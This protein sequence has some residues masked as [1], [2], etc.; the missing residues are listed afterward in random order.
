FTLEATLEMAFYRGGGLKYIALKGKGT[1]ASAPMPGI[2]EKIK[3]NTQKLA[4][5]LQKIDEQVRILSG[6][7]LNASRESDAYSSAVYGDASLPE[8]LE[9][10]IVANLYITYDADNR[11]LHGN[12]E[13]FARVG[14]GALEGTGT[15]GRAGWATIHFS[16]GEWYVY[17]GRPED[18]IGLQAGIGPLHVQTN[19]YLMIGSGIPDIP[20]PPGRISSFLGNVQTTRENAFSGLGDGF[21]F[22]ASFE[23]KTGD[24]QFLIFYGNFLAEAGFDLSLK[25]LSEAV[26]CNNANHGALGINGWYAQGQAYAYM[27]GLIGIRVKLFEKEQNIDIIDLTTGLWLQAKLPNPFWM[28]GTVGGRYNILGGLIKGQCH[29]EIELGHQCGEG[30]SSVL[31]GIPLIADVTP[32]ENDTGTDVFTTPQGVF[33]IP[34]GKSF[35]IL[36]ENT[37]KTYRVSLQKFSLSD[38]GQSLQADLEWNAE[39]DVVAL[40]PHDILPPNKAL[41]LELS[42]QFEVLVNGLWT[43][44]LL[45]GKV[46]TESR[47]V[48]FTTGP[49]PDY[50]PA[51]NIAY[52]YPMINQANYYPGEN[53]EGYIRLVRGQPY[54]FEKKEGWYQQGRLSASGFE[55][56]FS[57]TY[58]DREITYSLPSVLTANQAF[59]FELLDIPQSDQYVVDENILASTT[60]LGG[61][62]ETSTIDI[63][64]KKASGNLSKREQKALFSMTF[65]SSN[66]KTFPEKIASLQKEEAYPYLLYPGIHDIRYQYNHAEAFGPR[67]M[68]GSGQT[69]PLVQFSALLEGPWFRD[70]IKPLVY[71]ARDY[72]PG[73][74]LVWRSE[75][76]M[77]IPPVRTVE[78]SQDT[79]DHWTGAPDAIPGTHYPGTLAFVNNLPLNV[80]YD[81]ADFRQQAANL[82]IKDWNNTWYRELVA[83]PYPALLLDQSYGFIT[84]YVLPGRNTV[85]SEVT[86]KELIK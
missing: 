25:K 19:A 70:M 63:E 56:R 74:R 86:I 10:P 32:P 15:N 72:N 61:T 29:F 78:I 9:A 6:G 20:P 39:R 46:V 30:K 68:H 26:I 16:P 12:F 76:P 17:I 48:S 40:K 35:E 11:T 60:S 24:R 28:K 73:L 84:R 53:Q 55:H 3:S 45:R 62:G 81:Y 52:S 22:G 37:R 77:G 44:V 27:E 66:Y 79:P 69:G 64:T 82:L 4:G 41:K 83:T 49:A 58:K 71:D 65:R 42:V 75:Q 43:P 67:E 8:S 14:N 50:I 38:N 36:E 34:I 33:N 85:T 18:R 2:L 47:T 7:L 54:L 57:F 31:E 21:A 59:A 1:F 5:S 51:N 80:Y 13:V 23:M